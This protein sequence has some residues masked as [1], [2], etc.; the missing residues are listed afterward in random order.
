MQELR[1]GGPHKTK[2]PHLRDPAKPGPMVKTMKSRVRT[3]RSGDTNREP[4]KK[5]HTQSQWEEEK[6]RRTKAKRSSQEQ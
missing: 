2:D 3:P 5:T 4:N 1:Q 6:G